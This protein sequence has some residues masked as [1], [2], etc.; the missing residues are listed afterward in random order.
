MMLGSKHSLTLMSTDFSALRAPK[1]LKT[2]E[3][4]PNRA[5]FSCF[6]GPKVIQLHASMHCI[7]FWPW[8]HNIEEMIMNFYLN[9]LYWKKYNIFNKLL[10]N[11]ILIM[12]TKKAV[13]LIAVKREVA[14]HIWQ[15]FRGANVKLG[16]WRQVTVRINNIHWNMVTTCGLMQ[17]HTGECTVTACRTEV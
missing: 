17:T 2:F 12:Y 9:W 13:T 16:N 8:H 10:E 14:A 1:I 15:V 4:R 5:T 3:I 6:T 11:L 7:T